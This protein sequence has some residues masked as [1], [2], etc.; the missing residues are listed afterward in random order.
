MKILVNGVSA[1]AGGGVT[2]L[3]N[4]LELLPLQAPDDQFL[5]CLPPGILPQAE[6]V[7]RN[8]EVRRV[9]EAAQGLARRLLWENTTLEQLA[10][11]EKSDVVFCPANITPLARSRAKRVVMV[12]NVAPFYPQVRRLLRRFEGPGKAL[13]MLVLQM[14]SLYS[15]K[16]ADHAICLSEAT[17]T[18]IWKLFPGVDASVLYHGVNPVFVPVTTRPPSLPQEP[19]FVCVSSIYV[20]KGLEYL[21]DALAKN[22]DLPPVYVLGSPFD[23]GYYSHIL[24]KVKTAGLEHRILFHGG[25]PH[26]DLPAWYTHA[27]AM[28]YP[29]WCENCPN[30]LIEAMACG[31]PVVA[32]KTGPMPEICADSAW[33]ARPFDS[34][35]FGD[36][37]QLA[38]LEGMSPEVRARAARRSARFTREVSVEALMQVLRKYS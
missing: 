25:V 8:I 20:Y 22:P 34:S 14:M 33:Y 11:T 12:R 24:Q 6:T 30:I 35:A 7:G 37:M 5:M 15:I 27:G 32:M 18:L 23:Q 26:K 9:A 29:S 3:E 28:I 31:C 19:F 13:H 4:L 17:R 2:Y 38:R 10:Q 1:V 16:H 36:A 21:V